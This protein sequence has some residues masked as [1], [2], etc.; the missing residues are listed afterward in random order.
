MK[1]F[2]KFS[3]NALVIAGLAAL[4]QVI[5]MNVQSFL[6]WIGFAAWACFFISGANTKG[7]VKVVSC[8]VAGVIASIAI[9]ELGGFLTDLIGNAKIGFPIAVGLIAYVVILF[10]RVPAL[11]L[12]PAWFVGAACY[13][14]LHGKVGFVSHQNAAIAVLLSCLIAQAFGFATVALQGLAAKTLGTSK[15]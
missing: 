10:E 11:D 3:P 2:L 7:A 4:M 8:W 14:A 6:A 1:D 12:I 9:L 15:K 5:D 13:F